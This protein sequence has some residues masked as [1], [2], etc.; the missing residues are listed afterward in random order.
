MVSLAESEAPIAATPD[1][2][3]RDPWLFN[4]E[5]GT[6]NLQTGELRPHRQT[7]MITK[8]A[9]VAYVA[10]ADC[11]R[12][13]AFLARVLPDLEVRVVV[14]RYLGYCLTASVREQVL[15]FAYGAGANGKSVLL[16]VMLAIFGDYGLRAAA[17]LVLAKHGETHPTELADL[18]GRRLVVVSEIEQGKAW[19]ESLIKRI[20][21]DTTITA[22]KMRQDFY[23]FAASHK[24]VIAANTKPTVRGTDH[25]IWRR[26]RLIPFEVTIPPAER[27][28]DL[29]G[30]L[31]EEGPG[32]LAWLVR[33]CLDWQRDGLGASTAIEVA[34]EE[35][36][37]DQDVLGHWIAE[38]CELGEAQWSATT[39]LYEN[40]VAWCK[41]SGRDPW[42]RDTMRAR[43]IERPGIRDARRDCGR[44]RGLAGIALRGLK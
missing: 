34:T 42:T 18:E 13:D 41:A 11:P 33:G 35:Y 14:Q 44:I 5:N 9:P 19:A 3:D 21:G 16:D 22:R 40:Y 4:V 36:Q 2:F 27:D 20:T 7:D 39:L 31:L 25:A 32:I 29:V 43:L 12:W 6:I 24:L 10:D 8:I 15:Q 26:M 28:K 38:T 23:S 1:A 17:D 30:K 37:H